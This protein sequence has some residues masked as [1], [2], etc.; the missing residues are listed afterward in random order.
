[1]PLMT[2][3]DG[4]VSFSAAPYS[5]EEQ[6]MG[7]LAAYHELLMRGGP[8][9][10]PGSDTYAGVIWE[11]AQ[12]G[13]IDVNVVGY[14]ENQAE[15]HYREDGT[16]VIICPSSANSARGETRISFSRVTLMFESTNVAQR[17]DV[18]RLEAAAERN[19]FSE[20]DQNL[21]ATDLRIL[22]L[23]N[24][25]INNQDHRNRVIFARER[26]RIEFN[27]M[28]TAARM[29]TEMISNGLPGS[30]NPILDQDWS[31]IRFDD[32]LQ[33]QVAGDGRHVLVALAAYDRVVAAAQSRYVGTSPTY[34]PHQPLAP[35]WQPEADSQQ[36]WQSGGSMQEAGTS[37]QHRL[38][39]PSEGWA[40]T[41][42]SAEAPH[43]RSAP[44]ASRRRRHHEDQPGRNNRRNHR[45]R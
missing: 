41:G 3:S 24:G 7:E 16:T 28:K 35:E 17:R 12:Y 30:G 29:E 2:S 19:D 45:Q 20:Y 39:R 10:R 43:Q 15:T 14:N 9:G 13:P 11:G 42:S 6:E 5:A 18:S 33:A 1:M 36:R 40:A 34:E 37:N 26:E 31:A 21:S 4:Y 25:D 38:D 32:F 23:W 27:G 22:E 44:G 8:L